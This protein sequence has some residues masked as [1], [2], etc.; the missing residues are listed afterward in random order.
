MWQILNFIPKNPDTGFV[1]NLRYAP[2][3]TSCQPLQQWNHLPLKNS[4]KHCPDWSGFLL[5]SPGESNS[6]ALVATAA[7]G[8]SECQHHAWEECLKALAWTV[9]QTAFCRLRFLCQSWSQGTGMRPHCPA[10]ETEE[11]KTERI[12]IYS[13]TSLHTCLASFPFGTVLNFH[14]YFHRTWSFKLN[15]TI[16]FREKIIVRAFFF[17]FFLLTLRK[18]RVGTHSTAQ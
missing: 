4:D 15:C 18:Y 12:F 11:F 17:F 13:K 16:K 8:I 2:P 6:D 14:C 7:P 9:E 3:T 5:S 10:Q 1:L